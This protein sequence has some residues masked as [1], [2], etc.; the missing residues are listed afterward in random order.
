L[1]EK[2]S[3]LR[4][5]LPK[6]HARTID[7]KTWTERD[8][9]YVEKARIAVQYLLEGDIWQIPQ[10]ITIMGIQR[11]MQQ[12]FEN[13]INFW[14]TLDHMPLLKEFLD[15]VCEDKLDYVIR[16]IHILKRRYI[17]EKRMPTEKQF[18]AALH[19]DKELQSNKD[20]IREVLKAL[21][22]MKTSVDLSSSNGTN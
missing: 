12:I 17:A 15:T 10:R 1:A 4:K 6:P 11:T 18:L 16:K 9:D 7:A 8:N 5:Y 13:N 14:R 19:P 20:V 3:P 21:Q 22:E 2:V